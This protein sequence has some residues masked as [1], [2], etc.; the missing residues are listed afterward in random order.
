[1]EPHLLIGALGPVAVLVLC[2]VVVSR[3]RIARPC[4]LLVISGSGNQRVVEPGEWAFQWPLV[5]KTDQI[6][7][8]IM[9]VDLRVDGAFSQGG[10]PVN[11]RAVATVGDSG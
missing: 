9:Q 10:I 8:R 11:L 6:D 5:E 3:I 2:A 4:E 1:M 7:L